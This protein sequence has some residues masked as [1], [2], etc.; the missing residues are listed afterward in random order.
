MKKPRTYEATKARW[1]DP[2]ARLAA[3]ERM[4]ELHRLA[5]AARQQQTEKGTS[6]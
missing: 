3:Q 2:E 5:K 6:K 4:R 1:K